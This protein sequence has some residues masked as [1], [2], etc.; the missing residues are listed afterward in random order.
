MS[1][2]P[3]QPRD[4]QGQWTDGQ[5]N[6]IISAARKAAGLK[7]RFNGGNSYARRTH[8]ENSPMSEWG[9]AMFAD[10][11]NKVQ[12]SYGS[13]VWNFDANAYGERVVDIEDIKSDI[14]DAF[15]E[16][17]DRGYYLGDAND[18]FQNL[19]SM[20]ENGEMTK[21]QF[22][23]TFSPN[24]IVDSA[25]AYDSITGTQWLYERVL[26]PKGLGAIITPDGA[27]VFD[28]SMIKRADK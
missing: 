12:E 4:D 7:K 6:T 21:D 25:Q 9:H 23:N 11:L 10:D 22:L 17:V 5:I 2:N 14:W 1:Y 18:E 20:Y 27:I 15:I 3:N 19:I 8:T 13:N 26:E 28:E 24:D 16:D